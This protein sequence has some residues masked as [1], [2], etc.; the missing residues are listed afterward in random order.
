[1][2]NLDSEW[3]KIY[4]AYSLGSLKASLTALPFFVF[5]FGEDGIASPKESFSVPLF[6][7]ISHEGWTMGVTGN[8]SASR[9]WKGEG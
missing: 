7:K 3:G 5:R 8:D 2:K 1:M 9:A 6:L 4:S